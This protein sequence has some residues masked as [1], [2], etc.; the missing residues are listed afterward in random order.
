M[1]KN[2]PL[3][4][5]MSALVAAAMFL[6]TSCVPENVD[7]AADLPKGAIPLSAESFR[8]AAGTKLGVDALGADVYFIEGDEVW[9]NGETYTVHMSGTTPYIQ[10]DE[11]S[12]HYQTS[13]DG[14]PLRAVYPASIIHGEYSFDPTV[15]TTVDIQLP[16]NFTYRVGPNGRQ[17]VPAPLIAYADAGSTSLHFKHLTAAITVAITNNTGVRMKLE[18]I[19]I[20][21]VSNTNEGGA[22]LGL[23]TQKYSNIS[24]KSPTVQGQRLSGAG[25]DRGEFIVN[26]D[27]D[28]CLIEKGDTAY[29]QVPVLPLVD[30]LGT[31]KPRLK[32]GVL[33]KN[34]LP[35]VIA[36]KFYFEKEQTGTQFTL[37]QNQLAYAPANMDVDSEDLKIDGTFTIG[38]D[39]NNKPKKVYIS[40]G[41]LIFNGGTVTAA[42]S[43]SSANW[44]GLSSPTVDANW[45]FA[46]LQ[47]D[48]FENHQPSTKV[49]NSVVNTSGSNDGY[50]SLFLYG[51]NGN[52]YSTVKSQHPLASPLAIAT[53]NGHVKVALSRDAG[54]DWGLR[55][56]D[57][58]FTLSEDEWQ[59]LLSRTMSDGK[60][61]Y[62]YKATVMTVNGM[63]IYPDKH[64]YSTNNNELI[65]SPFTQEIPTGLNV[66]KTISSSDAWTKHE[67]GGVAFLPA[68]GCLQA[69]AKRVKK[70][71]VQKNYNQLE[72]G[73]AGYYWTSSKSYVHF[74]DDGCG[75]DTVS[76]IYFNTINP[77]STVGTTTTDKR[78]FAVRL[79]YPANF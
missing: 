58:W 12:T 3:A 5:R 18:K 51:A 4:L 22:F 47:Y 6:F 65:G 20:S 43:V 79:V 27:G 62:S 26:F 69:N 16:P 57:G 32:I 73:T 52:N 41:N 29:I 66:A 33:A 36:N 44:S 10:I 53:T 76:G 1:L 13:I 15:S 67:N 11:N 31:A 49:V 23:S 60:P 24:F 56:G 70:T 9:I 38:Y 28:P 34:M 75:F 71:E 8:G 46:D 59:H 35:G 14:K 55:M 30:P 50:V 7:P 72:Y 68:A 39:A 77:S 74:K 25:S 45:K 42:T 17:N 37:A 64:G 2:K 19:V 61:L 48:R 40:R 78:S 54:S 63:L 21:E